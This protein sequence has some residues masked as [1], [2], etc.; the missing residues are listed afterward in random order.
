MRKVH[1]K[2]Q[3]GFENSKKSK[4]SSKL[5]IVVSKKVLNSFAKSESS[6]FYAFRNTNMKFLF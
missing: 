4:F 2:H 1:K 3:Y 5:I 6:K